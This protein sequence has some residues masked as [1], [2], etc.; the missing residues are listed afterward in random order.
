VTAAGGSAGGADL[1]NPGTYRLQVR[2]GT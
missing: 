2:S 1:F